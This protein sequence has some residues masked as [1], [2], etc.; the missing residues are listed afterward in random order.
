[1]SEYSPPSTQETVA[2][3]ASPSAL[4]AHPPAKVKKKSSGWVWLIVL[5]AVGVAG[6]YFWPRGSGTATGDVTSTSGKKG[7]KG[8]G[9]PPVDGIRSTQGN[10][11]V[12]LTGLGSVTPIY[13]VT[14][15]SRVDGQLMSLNYKEGDIVKKDD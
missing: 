2:R 6:Y 5:L 1:M 13:T 9:I 12:Y 11:G 8:A 14:V 3:P 10:I 4:E 15:K 7:G